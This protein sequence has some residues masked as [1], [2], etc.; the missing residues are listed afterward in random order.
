VFRPLILYIGLRYTRAKRRNHFISFISLISMMG[1]AL[2]VIALIT[3]MSVMNGFHD[4]IRTRVLEMARHVVV[5]SVDNTMHD[6]KPMQNEL[7]KFPGVLGA[8][9][10][11]N[12]QGM[13]TNE[14][15][16]KPTVIVGIL[17]DEEKAVSELYK[18]MVAGAMSSLKPGEF[19]IVLGEEMANGL[20]VLLGDKVTLLTPQISV[21]PV[22][23]LPRFKPFTVVGIFKTG[24]VSADGS[25]SF[26]HMRD[27]QVLYQLGPNVSGIRLKIKDIYQAPEFS[28]ALAATLPIDYL[29]NNWVNEYGEFFQVIAM[30]KTI[31]FLLL[32]LLVMVAAFNLV[33]TLVMV[34]T[35]K[36]AD[37]AI[38]RTFGATPRTIMGIFMV[39]GCV[40]GVMGTVFGLVG[41]VL[42]ALNISDMLA[43]FEHYFHVKLLSNNFYAVNYLPSKLDWHDVTRI[44]M[45]ALGMSVLATIYP[46]WT[47]SRTQPAEAL[48]YE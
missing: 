24:N 20:G 16:V 26:V 40:V 22:G 42:L 28:R 46:A 7:R 43:A 45:A 3:A 33:S 32:M 39:Q 9:P 37:I 23:M 15:N 38:L 31:I 21:T 4:V 44:T 11:V 19:G 1:I 17:P 5:T 34:V 14:G 47:A 10:Y 18:K 25:T 36:K 35:D 29:V 2:G 6:W 48:R 27:A 12:G 41:G 13:L 30:E 8:A